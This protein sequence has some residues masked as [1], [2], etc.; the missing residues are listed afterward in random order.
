MIP[1]PLS[2]LCK[3]DLSIPIKSAVFDI[4]P[5]NFFNCVVKYSF[6]KFSLASFNGTDKEFSDWIF[7][8]SGVF[9]DSLI[10]F[11][12]FSALSGE[13]MAILSIR[14]LNSLTFPCQLWLSI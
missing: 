9:K 14:F 1:K 4:L 11:D 12:I 6:S 2:F 13:R 10:I 7:L 8:I 3:A 5:L